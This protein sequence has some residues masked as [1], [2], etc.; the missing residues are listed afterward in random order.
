MHPAS[1]KLHSI[2]CNKIYKRLTKLTEVMVK[3][4]FEISCARTIFFD[5]HTKTTLHAYYYYHNMNVI[6]RNNHNASDVNR[7]LRTIF[8]SHSAVFNNSSA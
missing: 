8:Q 1:E 5:F 3:R 2:H 4:G 6:L 7:K